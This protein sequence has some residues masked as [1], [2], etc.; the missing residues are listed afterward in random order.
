LEISHDT[1]K[2]LGLNRAAKAL[3]LLWAGHPLDNQY[4]ERSPILG[5]TTKDYDDNGNQ[6]GLLSL[7]AEMA[8]IGTLCIAIFTLLLSLKVDNKLDWGYWAI[9]GPI[10]VLLFGLLIITQSRRLSRR[11][12]L[13]ARLSWVISVIC[14]IAFL[15]MLCL[16][17]DERFGAEHLHYNVIF[18]PAWILVGA[19]FLLGL[20]AIII[21]SCFNH[22]REERKQKYLLSGIPL[23][24]FDAIFFP[25]M[26]LLVLKLDGND[27]SWTTVFIPLWTTDAI[28]LCIGCILFAFTIGGRESATFSISQVG[29]F[30]CIIPASVACKVLVVLKLENKDIP[31]FYVAIP[32]LVF[33]LLIISCGLNIKLEQCCHRNKNSAHV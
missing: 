30:L 31:F 4:M 12:S 8:V 14:I 10:W 27:F 9:F 24:I 26:L 20:I 3:E 23:M 32:L 1:N 13:I 16:H 15:V 5:T 29:T 2:F 6:K 22:G 28:L 33:Q 25:F 19:F 17:F 18:M 7:F 21:G 11:L